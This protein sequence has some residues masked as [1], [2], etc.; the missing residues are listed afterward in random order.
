[1]AAE[2]V[3]FISNLKEGRTGL[4]PYDLVI[5]IFLSTNEYNMLSELRDCHICYFFFS[6][7]RNSAQ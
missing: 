4:A 7:E 5:E 2:V 3:F 6:A 1:M